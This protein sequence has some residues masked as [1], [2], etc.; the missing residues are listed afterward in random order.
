MGCI[1][2]SVLFEVHYWAGTSLHLG[3]R[4]IIRSIHSFRLGKVS[5]RLSF[6]VELLHLLRGQ[7]GYL[8]DQKAEGSFS[9][10]CRG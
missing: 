7:F 9:L 4:S 2:N 1:Q 10:L 3:R 6:Y 5:N 8:E